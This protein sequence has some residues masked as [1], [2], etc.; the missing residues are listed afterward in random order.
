MSSGAPSQA[1]LA[2]RAYRKLVFHAA[3]YPSYAVTGVLVGTPGATAV[4]HDVIPLAH[5]WHALSPMAEAGLAL[6]RCVRVHARGRARM[7]SRM[8]R[9]AVPRISRPG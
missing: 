2:P 1:E 6:V 3:K 9:D 5:H 7:H 8:L 4:V